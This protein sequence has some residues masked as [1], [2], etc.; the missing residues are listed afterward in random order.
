MIRKS[1]KKLIQKKREIETVVC[2]RDRRYDFFLCAADTLPRAYWCSE[3]YYI[4]YILYRYQ[5]CC[6][7][8]FCPRCRTA[9]VEFHK[10]FVSP[11]LQLVKVTPTA[12]I[13]SSTMTAPYIWISSVNLWQIHVVPL[14]KPWM[15]ML[16]NIASSMNA[17][18]IPLVNRPTSSSACCSSLFFYHINS[19]S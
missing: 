18:G 10:M 6:M 4:S 17:Q 9:F 7:V 1:Y 12:D 3:S 19:P 2:H 14:S 15:E 8:L 16:N 5:Y 11:F 13:S